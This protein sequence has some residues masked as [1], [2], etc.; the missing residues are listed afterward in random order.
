[1]PVSVVV[2]VPICC[3]AP[4]P[5]MSATSVTLLLRLT[6]NVPLSV[7]AVLAIDPVAPPLPSC[8]VDPGEIVVGPV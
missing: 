8:S 2:P 4:V 3:S 7:T 5:E 1:M 6:F